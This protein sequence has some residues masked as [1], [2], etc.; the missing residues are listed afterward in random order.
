M[1]REQKLQIVSSF[2]VGFIFAL[3]LGLSGMTQPQKVIAFLDVLGGWDPSLMF[4]MLGA[5]PVHLISYQIIKNRQSPLLDKVWHFPTRKDITPSLLVGSALFGIG[6]GLGGYCP[7]PALASVATF[8]TT[9][10]VFLVAMTLGMVLYR[11]HQKI[12]G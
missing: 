8:S 3:G 7:G 4:V 12:V 2:L 9:V 6:W 11:V 10:L 1:S 5:I